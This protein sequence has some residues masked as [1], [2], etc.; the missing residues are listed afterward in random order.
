ML[1]KAVAIDF[2]QNARRIR[3]GWLIA[4]ETTGTGYS[5]LEAKRITSFFARDLL[6]TG[7]FWPIL[8]KK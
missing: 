1:S 2:S 8:L 5:E 3:L 7:S 6:V 4:S